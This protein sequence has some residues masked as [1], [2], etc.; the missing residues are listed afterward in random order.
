[1]TRRLALILATACLLL[2]GCRSTRHTAVTEDTAVRQSTP[3]EHPMPDATTT[4]KREYTVINFDAT[5][6]GISASGQMRM[7]KDS[8]IWIC[9]NKFIELGRA[10]A[11]TD[12]VWISAP[13]L[14]RYFAGS[15]DDLRRLTKQD[16]SFEMMQAIADSDDPGEQLARLAAS[17]GYGAKVNI[18]SRRKA[19]RLKFPFRKGQP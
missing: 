5:V 17:M 13:L 3:D 2:A 11:T 4:Q 18:T 6:E 9:V 19:E 10:M 15:Y 16:V 7:A 8:V 1:M 14:D 12:S